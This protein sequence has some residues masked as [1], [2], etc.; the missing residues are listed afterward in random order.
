MPAAAGSSASVAGLQVRLTQGGV[1]LVLL[2]ALDVLMQVMQVQGAGPLL[3]AAAAPVGLL[4]LQLAAA[5]AAAVAAVVALVGLVS[6]Q[7]AAA[8]A[9]PAASSAYLAVGQAAGRL[10]DACSPAAWPGPQ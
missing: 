9:A 7:V 2:L 8:A 10:L 3:Q 5:S 4:A 1:L 6:Q